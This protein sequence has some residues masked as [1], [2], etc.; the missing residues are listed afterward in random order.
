VLCHT[1][2]LPAPPYETTVAD[3][4]DWDHMCSMLAEARPWWPAGTAF[5]Y[6]AV[7]F[8]FL[9]G[10]TIR[11]ATGV[12]ISHW[13]REL[14]T[15][16][17]GIEGDVHFGVPAPALD[18]VVT[19]VATEPLPSPPVGSAADRAVPAGIRPSASYANDPAV[20]AAHIP[21]QGTMTALGAAWVYAALLGH[22]PGVHL[23]SAARLEQMATPGFVGRD[24]VMDVDAAWTYGFSP[25]Q[26][27]GRARP[28]RRVFG[29]FGVNGTGAYAD[30]DAGVAV[31]VMRNRFD[32]DNRILAEV[33]RI[34]TEAII[35]GER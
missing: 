29:M 11:R 24:E 3:L 23:V 2:G 13:L 16:P 22:V 28:D 33:D 26:P 32:P 30:L 34:V 19:Q 25:H 21:S 8:G 10:E 12:T 9:V 15:G 6:H 18:R 14:I 20:L 35:D 5:G 17:L 7:T 27:D 4:C 31:A 1:A